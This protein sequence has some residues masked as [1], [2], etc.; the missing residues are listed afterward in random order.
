MANSGLPGTSGFVGEFMVIMGAVQ[1]NLVYAFLA[2]LTLILG[3]GYT[4]WM[5]K[6]TIFGVITNHHVNEM[7][8]VNLQEF[9]VL[10][11][12]AL[13]VIGMGVYPQ[14]FVAKMHVGVQSVINSALQSKLGV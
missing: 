5:Y 2:G 1:V 6:R 13:A 11:I 8:D 12:L 4:L 9:C 7:S 14:L 3:A 10:L